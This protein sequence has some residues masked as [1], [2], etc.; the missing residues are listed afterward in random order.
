MK[1]AL[2]GSNFISLSVALRLVDLGLNVTIYEKSQTGWGGAWKLRDMLGWK[3]R[4]AAWH[5]ILFK[6]E[7][8]DYFRNFF[9]YFNYD[10]NTL[11][12]SDT[13]GDNF[14][15]PTH[16]VPEGGIASFIKDLNFRVQECNNI[17]IKL[18]SKVEL[19]EVIDN[20]LKLTSSKRIDKFDQLYF[21]S[22]ADLKYFTIS[23][24]KFYLPYSP[25]VATH[26]MLRFQGDT[27]FPNVPHL[28][29]VDEIDSDFVFDLIGQ[30][31]Y[32][33]SHSCFSSLFV[34]RIKRKFTAQMD[35]DMDQFLKIVEW[36]VLNL[37]RLDGNS[38]ITGYALDFH[39][40]IYR[41]DD[42]MMEVMRHYPHFIKWVPTQ[43]LSIT[44]PY[45]MKKIWNG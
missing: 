23:N 1:V 16:I 45:I 43:D 12:G 41:K 8:I 26:I 35:E 19:I 21:N 7:E 44:I 5:V 6:N 34:I 27:R 36:Q 9:R 4:E 11:V 38:K 42:E 15:A 39:R 22:C 14:F 17:T 40:T 25:R 37:L 32:S 20:R 29:H 2:I 13:H 10:I 33:L 3:Q 28:M 30:L 31:D 18:G 24:K